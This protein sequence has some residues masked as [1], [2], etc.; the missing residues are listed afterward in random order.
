MM[1]AFFLIQNYN[2]QGL[3]NIG[4]VTD[5]SIKELAGMIVEEVEY[6]GKLF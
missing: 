2:E 3:V 5:F 4:C 1:F 6:E